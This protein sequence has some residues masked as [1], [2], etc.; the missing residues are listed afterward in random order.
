MQLAAPRP[1]VPLEKLELESDNPRQREYNEAIP[2]RL[3]VPDETARER[4]E[5]AIQFAK[6]MLPNQ[7][8]AEVLVSPEPVIHLSGEQNGQTLEISLSHGHF[9]FYVNQSPHVT[10]ESMPDRVA[11]FRK[12]YTIWETLIAH[13]PEGFIIYGPDVNPG[14]Q[15]SSTRENILVWLGFGATEANGDRFAIIREGK[16]T[17]LTGAE[18]AELVGED[19]VA[20]LFNQRFMVEKIIWNNPE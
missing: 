20:I 5:D 9:D 14:S 3:E 17:P 13:L 1:V 11:V 7:P 4:V 15:D 8:N 18:F 16:V 19:G 10:L 6:W 12:L 2:P